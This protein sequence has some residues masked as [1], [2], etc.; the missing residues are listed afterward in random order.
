MSINY[1]DSRLINDIVHRIKTRYNKQPA[2]NYAGFR[3]WAGTLIKADDRL[4]TIRLDNGVSS[5]MVRGV[6]VMKSRN[7]PV[8][9]TLN[10]E[11]WYLRDGTILAGSNTVSYKIGDFW[12]TMEKNT[13][14]HLND[15][16]Q[17]GLTYLPGLHGFD[18]GGSQTVEYFRVDDCIVRNRE[19]CVAWFKQLPTTT[20]TQ[21]I[22]ITCFNKSQLTLDDIK[23]ATDKGWTL[24]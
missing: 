16:V 10:R 14:E 6:W 19:Q 11:P 24:A 21:T 17:T 12:Y 23:I 5:A 15:I 8:T 4:I 1:A 3:S 2:W 18:V 22:T 7:K 20:S 9:E 13:I